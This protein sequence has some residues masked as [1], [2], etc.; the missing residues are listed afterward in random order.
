M[1]VRTIPT[2]VLLIFPTAYVLNISLILALIFFKSQRGLECVVKFWVISILLRNVKI[3]LLL[4]RPMI[5]LLLLIEFWEVVL[6]NA[7]LIVHGRTDCTRGI[8]IV[9]QILHL[10]ILLGFLN[11][12]RPTEDFCYSL[13]ICCHYSGVLFDCCNKEY[14]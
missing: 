7:R 4:I 1:S 11:R 13:S 6:L 5:L 2:L 14:N 10:D 9:F 12:Y 8:P 3:F